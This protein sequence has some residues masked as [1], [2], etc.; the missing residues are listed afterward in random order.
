MS[1]RQARLA[2]DRFAKGYEGSSDDVCCFSKFPGC[3]VLGCDVAEDWSRDQSKCRRRRGK[4]IP[5]KVDSR[6]DRRLSRGRIDDTVVK[7]QE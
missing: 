6:A 3:Q 1:S 2:S 4:G 5:Q 7:L